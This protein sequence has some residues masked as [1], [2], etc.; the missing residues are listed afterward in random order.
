VSNTRRDA[1]PYIDQ[2]LSTV[3]GSAMGSLLW[4]TGFFVL[5][6]ITIAAGH[7]TAHFHH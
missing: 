1:P 2:S 3:M 4:L 7:N 6:T 5:K